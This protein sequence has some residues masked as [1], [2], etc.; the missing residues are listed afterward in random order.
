KLKDGSL[1]GGKIVLIDGQ[2]RVTALMAALDGREVVNKGYRKH[3]IR[4]AYQPIDREFA[5]LNSAIVKDPEWIP[6]IA[7]MF[8]PGA[9]PFE[10][11]TA[12]CERNPHIAAKD[13]FDSLGA[14]LGIQGSPIGYIELSDHLDIETVT[15]IFIRVNSAGVALNQADFAMSKIAVNEAY[16][17]NVLRKAIDYFCHLA[18]APVFFDTMKNDME[19]AQTEYFSKISWLKNENDSLFDPTYTDLLRV[20]FTSEFHRGRLQDLVAMLSGRN[21]ATQQFEEEVVEESFDKLR[22]GVLHFVNETN[23]KQFLL[24]LRSAGFVESSM[25]GSNT[26]V[27]FSYILFLTLKKQKVAPHLI[28]RTVRR[29][30]VLSLLRGRYSGSFETTFESD[31]RRFTEGDPLVYADQ[32]MAGELSDAF[33]T[34]TLPQSLVSSSNNNQLFNLYKASQIH[35]NDRG[36]LSDADVKSL[37]EVKSDV[38]HLFPKDYLKK[39]GLQQAQ[40]NQIANLVVMDSQIN[41]AISNREPADYFARLEEQAQGGPHAWGNISTPEELAENLRA[42]CIPADIAGMGVDQYPEFLAQRRVLM[43]EKIR[44]YFEAL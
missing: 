9:S 8:Q 29:W 2:Q 24:L 37:V 28:Q 15:E 6:D 44:S 10:F 34:V 16:G 38:H 32:V 18:I 20:A 4:I 39:H 7:P 21:F 11:S 13:V 1:S 27:D 31:I 41:I 43:A 5:V 42:N 30:F 19:F 35:A 14:L 3:R 25:I 12:Y 40:Y 26:A 17:G 36:F 23:F 22:T 33:W